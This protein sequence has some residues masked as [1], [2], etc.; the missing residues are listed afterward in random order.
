MSSPLNSLTSTFGRSPV[1][2]LISSTRSS[3]VKSPC[4]DEFFSTETYTVSNTLLVL[5]M[6]SKCP[7]VMGSKLPGHTAILPIL[8][9]LYKYIY[10]DR[11]IDSLLDTHESS[12]PVT[13]VFMCLHHDPAVRIQYTEFTDHGKGVCYNPFVI[14]RIEEYQI[15]PSAALC[16]RF[17]RTPVV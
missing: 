10:F 17:E 12:C 11:P 1:T 5:S 6:M 9:F 16:Q 8:P 2:L 4:F 13:L 14:R 7:Y 15:E 3:G